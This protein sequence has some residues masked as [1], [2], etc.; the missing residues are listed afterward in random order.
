MLNLVEAKG[1]KRKI[2][3]RLQSVF[4][5]ALKYQGPH[6][7]GTA[8]GQFEN[9]LYSNGAGTIYFSHFIGADSKIP[10]YWNGFGIFD[11]AKSVQHIAVEVNVPIDSNSARVSGFFAK[12]Q[13]TGP[14]YLLHSGKIGGGRRGNG[15]D[16][17]LAWTGREPVPAFDNEENERRGFVIGALDSSEIVE[18]MDRFVQEVARFKSL[19][20]AGKA[21][22]REIQ[23]VIKI[24]NK[25]NPE[26]SGSKRGRT[27]GTIDYYS[28]H[29]DIVNA[30]R[31]KLNSNKDENENLV[32]SQFV[33][34]MLTTDDRI[35]GVYE[36]KTSMNRQYLYTAVGQLMVHSKEKAR[37]TIVLPKDELLPDDIDSTLKRLDIDV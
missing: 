25:F 30:L 6:K 26:F 9:D 15:K 31:A 10:R 36:V 16:A 12:D 1:E 32:N 3:N 8:G 4:K 24:Y 7:I 28:H 18:Q 34:L 35:L 13:D 11:P 2:Q 21:G 27:K 19:A 37:R 5:G 22:K 17:F 23:K 14:A 20:V 29:G 33:D